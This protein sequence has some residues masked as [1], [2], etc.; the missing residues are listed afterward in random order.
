[1]DAHGFICD[2]KYLTFYEYDVF[3]NVSKAI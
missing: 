1:M 2:E 3:Y